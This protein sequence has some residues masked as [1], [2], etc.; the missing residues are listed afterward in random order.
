[1]TSSKGQIFEVEIAVTTTI[2]LATF[3]VD[4]KFVGGNIRVVKDFPDV[5]PQ[6]LPRMPPYREVEFVIDPLPGLPLLSN[7]HTGCL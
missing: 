5:F 7:G 1:L 3:L 6:E 4:G 2:R